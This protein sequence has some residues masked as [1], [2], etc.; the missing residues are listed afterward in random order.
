MFT[1][2]NTSSKATGR[3]STSIATSAIIPKGRKE[4][5]NLGLKF[6]KLKLFDAISHSPNAHVK[7]MTIKPLLS[8][9]FFMLTQ[10]NMLS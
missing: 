2:K 4:F 5:T 1:T 7:K 8:L 6:E 9:N 10:P 3:G